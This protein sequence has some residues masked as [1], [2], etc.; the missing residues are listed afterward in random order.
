[1]TRLLLVALG[2]AIGSVARYALSGAAQRSFFPTGT[3]AVNVLGCLVIGFVMG[4]AARPAGLSPNLRL[5]LATG[6]CG[7]FTTY[8]AFG[9]ETLQLLGDGQ[10][11][12][13]GVNVA[14]Q[15][16]GG[17]SAAWVGLV[18]ARAL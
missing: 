14:A 16:V 4:L 2:G 15:L 17:L 13:A 12:Q 6:L 9:F 7:G 8:S 10:L 1:M 5:F 11:W 3:L 18:A